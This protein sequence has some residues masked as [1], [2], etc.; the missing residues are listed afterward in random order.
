MITHKQL[1][2]WRVAL[3]N[4]VAMSD[5]NDNIEKKR[6]GVLSIKTEIEQECPFVKHYEP[7]PDFGVLNYTTSL[8][9]YQGYMYEIERFVSNEYDKI[10]EYENLDQ[11]TIDEYAAKLEQYK[12]T[13]SVHYTDRIGPHPDQI[14]T[15]NGSYRKFRSYQ[16]DKT[17]AL[18]IKLRKALEKAGEGDFDL[19]FKVLMLY[20]AASN[21]LAKIEKTMRRMG[22]II[23]D[24]TV[25]ARNEVSDG[26]PYADVKPFRNPNADPGIFYNFWGKSL[27]KKQEQY[28]DKEILTGEE[29]ATFLAPYNYRRLILEFV[30]I[31]QAARA[32]IANQIPD[33]TKKEIEDL[34]TKLFDD[35][36]N[37]TIQEYGT[38]FEVLSEKIFS[39]ENRTINAA[40]DAEDRVPTIVCL[41]S[42][43]NGETHST[44]IQRH[45]NFFCYDMV[46]A[47]L[48]QIA[49]SPRN[50]NLDF[51]RYDFWGDNYNSLADQY[52]GKRGL[53]DEYRALFNQ[54]DNTAFFI[55]KVKEYID[56]AVEELTSN[57][58]RISTYF[59]SKTLAK[60]RTF[61]Q[62]LF[63]KF[64]QRLENAPLS[65][66]EKK[67]AALGWLFFTKREVSHI[68]WEGIT[69]T[70]LPPGKPDMRGAY[71]TFTT[72]GSGEIFDE[73]RRRYLEDVDGKEPD[74]TS[75]H[76][77][78][79]D[80]LNNA[81]L[82]LDRLYEFLTR[83]DIHV[84]RVSKDDF[85]YAVFNAD[86]NQILKDGEDL[87][88]KT[89][90]KCLIQFLKE[91][92]PKK[93]YDAV[94][95]NCGIEKESLKKVN[96]D[97]GP[98]KKFKECLSGIPLT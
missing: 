63:F 31:F 85:E 27:K 84:I 65:D 37:R 87:H 64:T 83:D 16:T 5:E 6:T 36:V 2:E 97:R 93:W 96:F 86:F 95:R 89:K 20:N 54:D 1:D 14:F 13:Q 75:I 90:V 11:E 52:K 49:F 24:T 59:M 43:T 3:H 94:S 67:N 17:Y 23:A 57:G 77:G 28:K 72:T 56:M 10:K 26:D 34:L 71:F 51:L 25:K 66:E 69:Y 30:G 60:A 80:P 15:Q 78:I 21:D 41:D 22:Y 53:P 47:R 70:N 61:Y 81:V 8:F 4:F 88:T 79:F 32:E 58:W 98:Q 74:S 91:K 45:I 42:E 76:L 19:H 62:D 7:Y 38:S 33:K 29:K 73:M 55:K 46:H 40:H 50:I 12:Q 39:W 48:Q 35:Y 92:F 18:A 82:K 68:R 9:M 44:C